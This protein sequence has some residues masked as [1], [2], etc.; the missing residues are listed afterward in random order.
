M[1]NSPDS[2]LTAFIDKA[3]D[4]ESTWS[5]LRWTNPITDTQKCKKLILQFHDELRELR[6]QSLHFDLM[7]VEPETFKQE[8]A[9]LSFATRM[10]TDSPPLKLKVKIIAVAIKLLKPDFI[11]SD[12]DG[13]V[14]LG[15][16]LTEY[17]DAAS[18]D[19]L[20]EVTQL[21]RISNIRI[22]E[23]DKVVSDEFYASFSGGEYVENKMLAG[24]IIV[25]L[26]QAPEHLERVVSEIRECFAYQR[27]MAVAVL[28][29]TAIEIVLRDIYAKKDFETQGTYQYE[30]AQRAIFRF[31]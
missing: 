13:A 25:Q 20:N 21:L 30:Q 4:L 18:E 29:R 3:K 1:A 6:E 19:V 28:C 26:A 7:A 22:D 11:P 24:S 12:L 9:V 31:S 8:G 16:L 15:D 23:S 5:A 2:R 27:Y 10:L 17:S 14:D